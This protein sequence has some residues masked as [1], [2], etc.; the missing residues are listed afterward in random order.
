MAQ[1]APRTGNANVS[2][3]SERCTLLQR[4]VREPSVSLIIATRDRCSQLARCLDAVRSMSFE[5]RWELIVVDNGS[6]DRTA[7]VIREFIDSAPF[8]AHYLF[9]PKPGLGNAHNAGVAI[10]RGTVLAFTDDD[11]YPAPDF[12]SRVWAAFDDP[13]LGYIVGRIM[14]HDPA[15]HPMTVNE[16]DG[17]ADLPGQIVSWGR[18]LHP[19]R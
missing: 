2:A 19:G 16:F 7:S 8:P 5:R 10:A 14:L 12:L 13:Q 9:E 3:G 18:R 15:D 1:F 17:A 4:A 6:M 11:C